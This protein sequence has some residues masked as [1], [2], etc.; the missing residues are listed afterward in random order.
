M[1]HITNSNYNSKI[2]ILPTTGDGQAVTYF[3]P[4]YSYSPKL[5]LRSTHFVHW[6]HEFDLGQIQNDDQFYEMPATI[7]YH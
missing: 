4:I 7:E 2:A 5:P 3:K 6:Q 1:C